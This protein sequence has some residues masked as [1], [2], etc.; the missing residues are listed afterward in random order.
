[1]CGTARGVSRNR[2]IQLGAKMTKR[3][4]TAKS[5]AT[6][7]AASPASATPTPLA[8]RKPIRDL[9]ELQ[10]LNEELERPSTGAGQVVEPDAN[11]SGSATA[12]SGAPRANPAAAVGG[13]GGTSVAAGTV[14]W[15]DRFS[16][17]SSAIGGEL[18][19]DRL[20][21][22]I[23]EQAL[24]L[25][26]ADR[27][28]LFLGR[29]DS[30]GLVP[31]F[32]VDVHGEELQEIRQ[33][34][35]TLLERARAG[36]MV[37]T[38][39]APADPRFSTIRSIRLNE[40][41]SIIS[42][43]LVSPSGVVGALYLDAVGAH[44]FPDP[45]AAFFRAMASVAAVALDKAILHSELIRENRELRDRLQG[46]G[47]ARSWEVRHDPAISGAMIEGLIGTTDAIEELRQQAAMAARLD[48]PVLVVGEPGSGRQALARAIH[49]ASRRLGQP[50]EVCDLGAIAA[51]QHRSVLM[52]RT[53]PAVKVYPHPEPGLVRQAEPGSLY[54]DGLEW[55]YAELAPGITRLGEKGTFRPLGSRRDEQANV[56]LFVSLPQIP[57]KRDGSARAA[58]WLRANQWFRMVVPPL[59]ERGQD[60]PELAA[61]HAR[62]LIGPAAK[63]AGMTLFTRDAL[64]RM[65]SHSWPGNVRELR[66]AIQR[67]LQISPRLPITGATVEEVLGIAARSAHA[68]LGPWSGEIRPMR[69]WTEEA[70]R[71]ALKKTG[72][73]KAAAARLL[74]LHRNTLVLRTK[75]EKGTGRRSGRKGKQGEER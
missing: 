1:M 25:L 26:Q 68:A 41:R 9:A 49:H 52:G 63:P 71:Q 66:H 72:G 12:A 54:L 40:M 11:R 17:V 24:R 33:V 58:V 53:G 50:F 2:T 21:K 29:A 22:T 14:A 3:N 37:I 18:D 32:A 51:D 6:G 15:I 61:F 35:R 39:N 28:I 42:G 30:A 4:R 8:A 48:G 34:S 64:D 10:E 44:A 45:A 31:V 65:A 23:L 16:G 7:S 55:A 59:R 5:R 57:S 46:G 67:M 69:E 19:L 43:P 75:G 74:G 20:A 62:E 13:S 47:P 38:G 36:E 60:L 73:N 56:R 27:G 70:I